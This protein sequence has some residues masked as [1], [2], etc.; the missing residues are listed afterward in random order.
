LNLLFKFCFILISGLIILTS[1]ILHAKKQSIISVGQFSQGKIDKWE[2]EK[3]I[4]ETLYSLVKLDG[5]SVLKAVSQNSASGLIKKIRIDLEKYPFLNWQWRIENKLSGEFDEKQKQGDDY[6]ARIYAV[7]SGGIAFW[8][9]RAVNYV[10]AKN[11][12]KDATWPNAFAKNNAV[13]KALRSSEA[14]V[15]VWHNEKRN[16]RSDFKT[17]FGKDMKFIDAVV[18]MT[19]T[20]NTKNYALSYY[21]DIYF[22]SN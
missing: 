3:F 18:I 11:S 7:A 1:G 22:S 17:L 15:S 12:P 21:G 16:I 14:M 19:D 5:Q 6:A 10:W 2:P 13:M 4:N 20:D 9:T 8:N